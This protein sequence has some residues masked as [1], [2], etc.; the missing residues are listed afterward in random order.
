MKKL[1]ALS[2]ALILCFALVACGD[3]EGGDIVGKWIHDG[4]EDQ[5]MTFKSN[6]ECIVGNAGREIE[7]EY[8][9]DGNELKL[10]NVG[11]EMVSEFEVDGDTLTITDPDGSTMELKRAD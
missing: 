9:V 5:Y 8:E 7:F 1:V 2:L 10:I 11:R 3:S 4:N 6:G